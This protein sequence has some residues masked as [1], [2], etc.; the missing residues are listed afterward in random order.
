MGL[1][2]SEA[3]RLPILRLYSSRGFALCQLADP[4]RL[5]SLPP[6]F[7]AFSDLR[8]L[9]ACLRLFSGRM[10]HWF[11]GTADASS[12]RGRDLLFPVHFSLDQ[13]GGIG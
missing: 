3:L 4:S 8:G 2:Q 1:A 13:R 7:A 9:P 5:G 6:A 10:R 11:G 12:V